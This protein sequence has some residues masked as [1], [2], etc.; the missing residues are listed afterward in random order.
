MIEDTQGVTVT[1]GTAI[2]KILNDGP[3]GHEEQEVLV[4]KLLAVT[5]DA[6]ASAGGLNSKPG[7]SSLQSM[8]ALQN[9]FTKNDWVVFERTAAMT[10]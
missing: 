9:F 3:F 4:S 8:A 7:R 5:N 10:S 6:N 1:E 2:I